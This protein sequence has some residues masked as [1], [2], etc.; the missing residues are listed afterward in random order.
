MSL[1]TEAYNLVTKFESFSP[2]RTGGVGNQQVIDWLTNY[3]KASSW[4]VHLDDFSY[5]HYE[6]KFKSQTY[7]INGMLLYYSVLGKGKIENPLFFR[8]DDGIESNFTNSS[9]LHEVEELI[10]QKLV[11]DAQ[12]SGY[13]GLILESISKSEHLSAI[14]SHDAYDLNFPIILVD[15]ET[16]NYIRDKK[17]VSISY[18]ASVVKNQSSNILATR[19]IRKKES[20]FV[21]TTPISGWFSCAGERGCGVSIALLVAREIAKYHSVDLIFANGHELGYRGAYKFVESYKKKPKA[22]L[23]LGSCLANKNTDFTGICY[24]NKFK[25]ISDN[26]TKLGILTKSPDNNVSE[27]E[28]VGESKCWATK[29][30]PMLS[31]AGTNPYFHTVADVTSSVTSPELLGKFI[32]SLSKAALSLV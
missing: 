5:Q 8:L 26:L 16:F 29:N 2:H 28:W 25:D 18:E 17:D 27:N 12:L 7:N 30:V 10:I 9:N 24:S 6:G 21:I 22:V 3:L 19:N 23:H 1:G 15:K 11:R 32:K 13:D 20:P 31:V 14:N 4:S